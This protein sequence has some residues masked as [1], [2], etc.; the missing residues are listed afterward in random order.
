[1]NKNAYKYIIAF[2]T[3]LALVHFELG[4]K[5]SSNLQ[6]HIGLKIFPFSGHL[7]RG[8]I[9]ICISNIISYI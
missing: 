4:V 6:F 2:F 7:E 5:K 8:H 1:M 9:D 3:I